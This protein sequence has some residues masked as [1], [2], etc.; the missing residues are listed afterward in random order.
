MCDFPVIDSSQLCS[1]QSHDCDGFTGERR[2]LH[3]KRVSTLIDMDDR[4][5]VAHGQLF[6][7]QVSCEDYALVFFDLAHNRS[8]RGYAVTNLG[9][10]L[11]ASR[12]Q[13]VLTRG[14]RLT[15]VTSSPSTT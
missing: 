9:P 4:A 14:E 12:I 5:H 10:A 7:R 15:G 1:I 6:C 3:F 8:S 13:T 11:P 2:E